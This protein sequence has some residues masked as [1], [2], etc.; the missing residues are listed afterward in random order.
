MQQPEKPLQHALEAWSVLVL[1]DEGGDWLR[2]FLPL[3]FLIV[4]R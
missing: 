3:R 4:Q 2:L 1:G